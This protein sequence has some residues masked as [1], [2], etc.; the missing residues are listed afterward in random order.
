MERFEERALAEGIDGFLGLNV[1]EILESKA[2]NTDIF[3]LNEK[4]K[5][6]DNENSDDDEN[7]YN[8]KVS[9]ANQMF[10]SNH[11]DKRFELHSTPMKDSNKQFELSTPMKDSG[12]PSGKK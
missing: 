10:E 11:S 9:N 3:V 5:A 2:F 12:L 8:K 4:A 6:D 7:E 1:D